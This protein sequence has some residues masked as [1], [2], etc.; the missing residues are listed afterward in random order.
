M[1]IM[2]G[3]INSSFRI[4]PFRMWFGNNKMVRL[5]NYSIEHFHRR[6]RNP[7]HVYL[8]E[9][10][11]EEAFLE[12]FVLSTDNVAG[13]QSEG[14]RQPLQAGTIFKRLAHL[15]K[16]SQIWLPSLFPPG[17]S[18]ESPRMHNSSR[19]ARFASD[20]SAVRRHETSGISVMASV[21]SVRRSSFATWN[22]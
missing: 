9:V 8:N 4:N 19:A 1:G 3:G 6:L 14:I 2:R 21:M 11:F 12:E 5:L 16:C 10:I 22:T 7:Q 17:R 20:I 13:V 18:A 15:L